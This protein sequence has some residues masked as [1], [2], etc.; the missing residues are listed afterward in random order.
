MVVS[1]KCSYNTYLCFIHTTTLH[2]A[3]HPNTRIHTD[4]QYKGKEAQLKGGGGKKNK[5]NLTQTHTVTAAVQLHCGESKE[6]P[7]A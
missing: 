3:A 1:F 7:P 2:S 4:T 6:N 5:H